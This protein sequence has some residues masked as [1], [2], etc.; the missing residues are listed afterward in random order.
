MVKKSLK[1]G[2]RISR[3]G[4]LT[5]KNKENSTLSTELNFSWNK[6]LNPSLEIQANTEINKVVKHVN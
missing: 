3:E 6:P 4:K 5:E 1:I 2:K